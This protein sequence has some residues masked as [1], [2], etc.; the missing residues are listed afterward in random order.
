MTADGDVKLLDFG[1]AKLLQPPGVGGNRRP[2]HDPDA[3]AHARL[4]EPRTDPRQD[5]HDRERRVLARRR[6]LRAA[7]R[8]Q[9]LPACARY[10]GGRDPRDL[11]HRAAAAEYRGGGGPS[12]GPR[13]ARPR[14][15][16]DHPA[17]AAQGARAAL[18]L[19]RPVRRRRRPLPR[20]PAGHCARRRLQ[21][22]RR[23][24][25]PASSPGSGCGRAAR[26]HA[27]RRDS[28]LAARSA[29]RR[30]AARQGRAAL[31]E[32]ARTREH[33]PVRRQ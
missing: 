10:G 13:A 6:A 12:A 8:P 29:H 23:Q 25:R 32:R 11:Q 27:R 17:G 3:D 19:G 9:P 22:P 20:R 33:A 4:L 30:R 18:R 7:D 2:D 28:L 31:R 15:R 24:V 1:I 5:D 21:L 14:P 16:R 26:R